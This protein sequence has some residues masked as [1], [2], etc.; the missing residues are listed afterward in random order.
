MTSIKLGRLALTACL[1]AAIAASCDDDQDDADGAGERSLET[2]FSRTFVDVTASAGIAFVHVTGGTGDKLLPETL[3]AGA[4]FL[5][6]DGDDKLD[7]FIVNS[8]HWPGQEPANAPLPTSRLYRGRGDGR[9]DDVTEETGAGIS[10]YGMGCSIAD[11][12]A[13]GDVDIY[14]TALGDNV[15]LRNDS[16]KFLDVTASAGVAG[17]LWTDDQGNSHPEW[18]TA[19]AWADFDR[20]GDLD[21]FVANYVQWTPRYEVFT[22]LDGASKAFTTPDRYEGLPCRL[23]LNDGKGAFEDASEAAGLLAVEGKSLGIALSDLDGDDFLDVVVANDTRPNFLFVNRGAGRF[24][25]RGLDLGIA[26]DDTGRARA[27]MGI[28][29]ATYTDDGAASIAIGNFS[30]EPISLWRRRPDGSFASRTDV[31]GLSVATYEPL[32]FAVSFLDVDLDGRLD[33]LVVNGHIEPD[34][35]DSVS[36]QTHA[37]SS[38]LFRGLGGEAF[39][40]ISELAGDDFTR[41]RVGRGLAYGDIDRDGDLDLLMTTNGG[42]VTLL[43]NDVASGASRPNFLRVRLIGT[44]GNLDAIGA[45]VTLQSGGRRQ[46]RHVTTGSS[47]LSQSELTLTFGLGAETRVDRLTVRWP[48]GVETEHDILGVNQTL[49]LYEK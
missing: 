38:Q 49:K 36:T 35:A 42:P 19:A 8:Q 48:S 47:Y 13:D 46:I 45:R 17:G 11:Y 7:I 25:E 1:L 40:D 41:A 9:F 44:G 2:R 20:D 43:R 3:G 37:Q 32:A 12:D 28:D 31:A 21:L 30:E 4:A 23:F 27:G 33:L 5:D 18:S 14:I 39:D 24:E 15:L 10:V 34:I 22:T 6:F 26:Y 16:G 29:I